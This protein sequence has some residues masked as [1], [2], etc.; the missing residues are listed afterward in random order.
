MFFPDW[1]S[2]PKQEVHMGVKMYVAKEELFQ[3][4]RKAGSLFS[5]RTLEK[6]DHEDFSSSDIPYRVRLNL[7]SIEIVP[8]ESYCSDI[9]GKWR[10]SMEQY[11]VM[12]S[13]FSTFLKICTK[14]GRLRRYPTL[15]SPTHYIPP[16]KPRQKVIDAT[17]KE[18]TI[19]CQKS[20]GDKVGN[21]LISKLLF[22]NGIGHP[23]AEVL[24]WDTFT[25]LWMRQACA[26]FKGRPLTQK[27]YALLSET[28]LT[29]LNITRP[30]DY[31]E[32]DTKCAEFLVQVGKIMNFR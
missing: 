18:K 8:V 20:S 15:H 23:M 31:L 14:F 12:C 19:T 27:E 24:T 5:P 32:V 30:P 4:G 16:G 6:N 1:F 29:I 2:V 21:Y 10:F 11:A 22:V 9:K 3:N 28:C 17:E 7:N 13:V 26:V 25:L